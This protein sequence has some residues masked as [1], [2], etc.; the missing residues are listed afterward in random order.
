MVRA[1]DLCLGDG[2]DQHEQ[3]RNN[4]RSSHLL[5]SPIIA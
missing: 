1:Y 5:L 4:N 3:T 2:P